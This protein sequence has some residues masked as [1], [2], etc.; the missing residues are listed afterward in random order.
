MVWKF[1]RPSG[2][3]SQYFLESYSTRIFQGPLRVSRPTFIYLCHFLGLILSKK[4][5][6]FRPCIPIYVKFSIKL[7]RLGSGD[8]LHTLA[9][10]YGLSRPSVSIIVRNTCERI[11]KLLRLFVFQRPTLRKMKQI[12]IEFKVLH[13]IPYILEAIDGSYI[14]IT[15]LN[16]NHVSYYYRIRF[17]SLLLQGVVDYQCKFWDSDFGW[18]ESIHDWSSFQKSKIRKKTTNEV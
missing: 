15:V 2:Y 3:V 18:P 7:P 12:A 1:N 5:T 13:E 6:K 14:L 8:T 16:I 9:D 11:K 10:L 17:Y 4:N